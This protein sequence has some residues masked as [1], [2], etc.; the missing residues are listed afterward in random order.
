M[1]PGGGNGPVNTLQVNNPGGSP[2]RAVYAPDVF[3]INGLAYPN[4]QTTVVGP[5]DC[6]ALHFV[7]MGLRE[8]S[9]GVLGRR[10]TLMSEDSYGISSPQ[11]VANHYTNPGEEFDAVV[12]MNGTALGT[13]YPIMDFEHHLHN[14]SGTANAA[15]TGMNLGGMM[16]VLQVTGGAPASVKPV[17]DSISLSQS[18][19][20]Y[21]GGAPNPPADIT[22]TSDPQPAA[23]CGE[24]T[25]DTVDT[26]LVQSSACPGTQT[27]S[28]AGSGSIPSDASSALS[29]LPNGDHVVWERVRDAAGDWSDPVGTVLTVDTISGDPTGG[30]L[31]TGL[32][33]DPT[34]TNG[35]TFNKVVGS[36]SQATSPP[37][38]VNVPS[39]C[40]AYTPPSDP[41]L[42][43]GVVPAESCDLIVGGTATPSLSDWQIT[44]VNWSVD[45]AAGVT[46]LSGAPGAPVEVLAAVPEATLKALVAGGH[47]D[48]PADKLCPAGSPVG[49]TALVVSANESEPNITGSART[50]NPVTVCFIL[51]KTG[52]TATITS[53]QPNPAGPSSDT[54]GNVNYAPSV[55]IRGSFADNATGIVRAE[56][57]YL[58]T[59]GHGTVVG[60]LP[61]DGSGVE[62]TAT[63]GQWDI[64]P[65]NDSATVTSGAATVFDPSIRTADEG[66]SVSDGGTIPAGATVGQVM[67]KGSDPAPRVDTGTSAA[68]SVVTDPFI[69]LSDAGAAVTGAGIPA[70]AR[71]GKV[72][73]V[74]HT[75]TILVGG[76]A[77]SAVGS[78]TTIN[79]GGY[80]FTIYVNGVQAPAIGS[81]SSVEIGAALDAYTDLPSSEFNGMPQGT[82][83]IYV[84]AQDEAGNWGPWAQMA[85]GLDKTE[86]VILD[87][88]TA[89][90][91][92]SVCAAGTAC[93]T[94]EPDPSVARSNYNPGTGIGTYKLTFWAVDPATIPPPCTANTIT[95]L[96]CG[97]PGNSKVAA[98][99][100]TISYVDSVDV[101]E[102]N[103]F[104]QFF[105]F[106]PGIT[107]TSDASGT[108]NGP[109]KVT[110]DISAG[111]QPYTA[112][113]T[114]VYRIMDGAGNWTN[115]YTTNIPG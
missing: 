75:F 11:D 36:S 21:G 101:T 97:A 43:A 25:I 40:G 22:I 73:S 98:I 113:A 83:M 81:A 103:D 53:L 85:L 60:T 76:V 108:G 17:I 102:Q 44:G 18:T 23:T 4:T 87:H 20:A 78:P 26:A 94:V 88:S 89:A 105:G 84:H 68:G 91:P 10:E 67:E 104:T 95:P 54:D 100:W 6:V 37:K 77:T 31:L 80:W 99:E 93:Q 62:M 47:A 64:P 15:S 55:R 79:V 29:K 109:E 63:R 14:G 19:I 115:W 70:D 61:K 34:A 7:D 9:L 66:R 49:S 106:T 32:H 39:T 71:V 74:N 5:G 27:I 82:V 56:M 51:T 16:A 110:V 35:T 65:R 24:W 33:V 69:G 3:L 12:D 111:P 13:N 30:P 57:A 45:G 114:V 38:Q 86:P 46:P 41:Y 8:K 48:Q 42:T 72:D 52:P 92:H 96:G 58:P 59:D 1:V 112:P 28:G 50:G 90:P 107:V 2:D